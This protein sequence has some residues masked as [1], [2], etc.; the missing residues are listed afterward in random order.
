MEVRCLE[1]HTREKAKGDLVFTTREGMIRG[2]EGGA[3]L[4]P[5]RPDDSE[6][7]RRVRLASADEDRMPPEKHGE[8]LE[9]VEI[10]ALGEWIEAGA[11]WPEG[12]VLSPKSKTALPRWDAPPATGPVRAITSRTSRG[13][14]KLPASPTC[15]ISATGIF[16]TTRMPP[17]TV[18]TPVRRAW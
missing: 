3:A 16:G 2:G 8:P 10:A 11:P 4:K 17:K 6:L 7:L 14:S 15:A 5:G 18:A 13:K 9:P 1:C 12:E